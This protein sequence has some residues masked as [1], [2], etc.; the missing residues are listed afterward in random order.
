MLKRCKDKFV[1]H[2]CIY[3]VKGSFILDLIWKKIE[4]FFLS[5]IMGAFRKVCIRT[6]TVCIKC[7]LLTNWYKPRLNNFYCKRLLINCISSF[8]FS[9]KLYPLGAIKIATRFS[10]V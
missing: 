10:F 5:I 1:T 7:T 9:F 8:L 4:N 6:K 2:S 3:Y